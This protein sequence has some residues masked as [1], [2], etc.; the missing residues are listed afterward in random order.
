MK[1]AA[2]LLVV[3]LAVTTRGCEGMKAFSGVVVSAENNQPLTGTEIIESYKK[4]IGTE[5]KI[6]QAIRIGFPVFLLTTLVFWYF[7][8]P[9]EDIHYTFFGK[10]ALI[11]E[12]LGYSLLMTAFLSLIYLPV[13]T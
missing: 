3:M 13:Y 5:L 2:L 10:L 7:T 8:N 4:F 12:W 9:V 6:I 11:K 1:N